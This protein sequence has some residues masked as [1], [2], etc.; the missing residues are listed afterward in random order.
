MPRQ[1]KW[2]GGDLYNLLNLPLADLLQLYPAEK[3]STLKGKKHYWKTKLLEGKITMPPKPES[4]PN[5]ERET[6]REEIVD[7]QLVSEIEGWYEMVT[8]NAE[9][10]AEVHRLYKHSTKKRPLIEPAEVYAQAVPAKITPSRRKVPTR[11]HKRLFVFSDAQIDYRRHEDGSLEPIHDERALT[12]ARLL[13]RDFMPDEIINTG[14]TVDLAALGAIKY[15][16]DSNHFQRT[17][18]P[19]FQRTHN[20]YAEYRA[21]NPHAKIT[22]VDSNHNTRLKK[23]FLRNTPEFYGFQRPGEPDEFPMFTYPYMINAKVVGLNWVSGYGAAEYVYG[24]QY[25]KPPIIFKHGNSAVSN[26]STAA[27]ESRENPE[28]H[29]VRGH[30]HRTETA[31]RTT[32]SGHYLASIVVGALCRID[33]AVPGYHSAVD[34][35]GAVVKKQQNWQNSVLLIHDYDGDYEFTHVMIRDGVARYQGKVY[36]G[37]E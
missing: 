2:V 26:S 20:M 27:K 18:A 21:D 36:N 1:A 4:Q 9:G 3:K 8:K 10:E 7:G 35:E 5:P 23:H 15:G 13:C 22:E 24:E 31:H 17:L 34:D 29:V 11:D 19:S 12:V 37:N 30:S 33:G 25:D 16:A 32:R 28:T 6:Y 14:D